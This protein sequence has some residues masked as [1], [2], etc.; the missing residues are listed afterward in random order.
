[1]ASILKRKRGPVD[2]LDPSK[3]TKQGSEPT[4]SAT[5]FPQSNVGWDV[6]ASLERGKELVRADETDDN[7]ASDDAEAIDFEDLFAPP[8]PEPSN[9]PQNSEPSNGP[10]NSETKRTPIRTKSNKKLWEKPIP[11]APKSRVP[12]WMISDS[13]GGRIIN[14]EPVFAKDEKYTDS[15]GFRRSMLISIEDHSF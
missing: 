10:Q 2:V 11:Q 3:R 7:G 12:G 4:P 5:K 8:L 1:M 14:A 15:A 9:E 6:F 13:V